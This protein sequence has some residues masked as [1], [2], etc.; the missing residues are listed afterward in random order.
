MDE[1]AWREKSVEILTEIKEWR[2]AHP[3]A[4]YVEIEDEVHRRMMQLEAQVLQDAVQ[5]SASREWGK[6]SGL[7]AALCPSCAVPL[8]ARGK[9][10]R[11]LQGN[12]GQPVILNRTNANLP[13]MWRKSFSPSMRN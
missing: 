9:H 10:K 3:K 6:A 2:Q 13:Q 5:A 12:G 1:Q 4:T 7:P 8:Q 11:T